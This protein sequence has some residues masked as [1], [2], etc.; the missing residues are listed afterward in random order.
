MRRQISERVIAEAGDAPPD[1][2]V[3]R[4]LEAHAETVARLQR[5]HR[6]L[7]VEGV[8]DLAQ[9]AVALRQFRALAG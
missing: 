4:F 3:E 7:M 6:G 1:E 5:F 9:L 8:S 2:A